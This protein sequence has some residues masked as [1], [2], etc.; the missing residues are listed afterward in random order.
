MSGSDELGEGVDG[1]VRELLDDLL[2]I[3]R[4]WD[5]ASGLHR[6]TAALN[7]IESLVSA[8]R[9]FESEEYFDRVGLDLM[10]ALA[11][12]DLP[13]ELVHWHPFEGPL[14]ERMARRSTDTSN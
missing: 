7:E 2:H 8:E 10:E 6:L 5:P 11:A 12:F 3:A 1:E 14:D 4:S 13:A 9:T